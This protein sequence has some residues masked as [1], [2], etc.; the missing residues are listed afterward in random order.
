MIK[1][2]KWYSFLLF[3]LALLLASSIMAC[4][5]PIP[6]SPPAITAGPSSISFDAQQGRANPAS[7]TLSIWNSG[8]GTLSWSASDNA[9]WLILSPSSGSSTGE[10]DNISLSVDISGMDAGNYAAVI[11]ISAS[12]AT[13]TPQT[14]VVNLTINPLEEEEKVIDALDTDNL[15][16]LGYNQPERVVTVEGVI[17]RTYYA[18]NS[19]GLPTFL[20]FHD[21]YEG[22][23]KCIIWKED[24]QTGEPIRDK[25]IQAFPPNPETYFLNK[26]VRVKGLIN[27]YH[28]W[29]NEVCLCEPEI[30]LYDP[31]QIW[32]VE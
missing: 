31:S 12:E 2:H 20:D 22:Y 4:A 32:I 6:S 16:D 14:M 29:K 18:K 30:I 24:R 7:Q 27:V 11:T 26:K 19:K 28:R 3:N 17:V 9:D 5:E 21:P 15:L 13:N 1:K 10:I 25:F 8:G 23:F